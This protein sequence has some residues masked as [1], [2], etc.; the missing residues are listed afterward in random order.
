MSLQDGWSALHLEMPKRIF[1][2]YLRTRLP[3]T[4]FITMRYTKN[5]Q[6]GNEPPR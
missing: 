4:R 5:Y 1:G 2:H 6:K 3:K